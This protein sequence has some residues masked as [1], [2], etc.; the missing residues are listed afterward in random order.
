MDV[1]DTCCARPACPRSFPGP[2]HRP[3]DCEQCSRTRSY[4]QNSDC[5]SDLV[6]RCRPYRSSIARSRY[7]NVCAAVCLVLL[8]GGLSP[9]ST[10]APHKRIM[11]RQ[12]RSSTEENSLW[13]NPC[14]YASDTKTS[15][16]SAKFAKLVASQARNALESTSKYK[17][18]FVK[19]HSFQS[20]DALLKEWSGTEWLRN[21]D[22]LENDIKDGLP[23]DNI[24]Y[25]P[26]SEQYLGDLMK[27]IDI[28]LPSMYKGLKMVVAGLY[29]ISKEGLNDHISSD[30][31]LKQNITQSMHDIRA[32]LCLFNELMLSRNLKIPALP[33]SEVP[34]MKN[35]IGNAFLV[36]RDTLH[37]LE[38]L[39]QVF[40]KMYDVD[41]LQD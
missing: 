28:E 29:Y 26:M 27:K 16:Y 5:D 38:Y 10:A 30:A 25:Q 37:Y 41:S 40:Q 39:A 9:Q 11:D 17:D 2:V 4:S 36:Y 6:D 13:G 31:S 18:K 20:Y 35:N 21:F 32:V 34:D 14:D 15:K 7:V 33:D 23:K 12:R 22:W 3:T 1:S 19:L 24:A 8:V